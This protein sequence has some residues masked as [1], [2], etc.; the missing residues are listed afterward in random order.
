MGYRCAIGVV[1]LLLCASGAIAQ[2]RGAV[3]MG[4]DAGVTAV[5][6][7]E[8]VDLRVHEVM[9]GSGTSLRYVAVTSTT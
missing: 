3:E 5:S 2:G 4:V 1:C 8:F 9:D 6:Y 7:H